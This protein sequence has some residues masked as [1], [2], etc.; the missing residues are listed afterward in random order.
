MRHLNAAALGG[1]SHVAN[2]VA[3]AKPYTKQQSINFIDLKTQHERIGDRISERINQVFASGHFIMG[4]LIDEL[5]QKLAIYTGTQHAVAVSS[6]TDALFISLLARGIGAG[7][8]VFI[9]GFTFSATAEV[10]VLA[11]ATP[12][13]VDVEA[14]TFNICA[15]DL[16]QQIATIK[17]EDRLRPAAIMAVD[18]FGLPADYQ[19]LRTI[20]DEHDLY[21]IGDAA[22]SFGASQNNP[23][24]KVQRV[25][26]LADVTAT[27]F[28]PSKPLGC[29][30]D[31]G[32]IF[33]NDGDLANIL[34]SIRS[35]GEGNGAYDNV[36]VG[37]NGRL[38]A[39]QAAVLLEKLEIFD[40][41][42]KSR[43]RIANTYSQYLRDYVGIPQVPDNTYPS[44]AQ[45]TIC[46]TK[47]D[48]LQASLKT[49]NIPTM[50]YYP[51]P[52]HFQPAYAIYG[53]GPGS[54]PT[55]ERL[56]NEVISL[57]FH[58]YLKNDEISCIVD[59]IKTSI[60]A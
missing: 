29:Y 54:L 43:I 58:P 47:R 7:D 52:M 39:I 6:G 28:Y 14:D 48:I 60:G 3:S 24:H 13:F 40:D 2:Y 32:A 27:S 21:L 16:R 12:V 46:T 36:R 25:G 45:Y 30:G 10:I 56:C 49:A 44:W 1:A 26:S 9:P 55:S 20:C 8:A 53:N 18:L 17:K 41:E 34:R 22:Q 23:G 59:T 31:G 37:V 5:E 11:G 4:P 19:A 35:H 15:A 51:R 50:I 33:T 42:L 57:P 38:D